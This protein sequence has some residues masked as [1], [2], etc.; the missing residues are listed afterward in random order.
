[1]TA[2]RTLSA[3]MLSTF[4]AGCALLA[5]LPRDTKLDQRLAMIP[6]G[7]L[8][9]KQPVAI[10][11][12]RHQIPFIEAKNDED[13]A[14]A[15][16]LVHAHLRLGQ[17]ELMRRVSQGRISEMAGPIAVDIDH[18]LRI[19]N[20]GRAAAETEKA[21]PP[22][23][24]V[25]AEAFVRGI[26]HYQQNVKKLPAEFA[27]LGMKREPWEVRDILTIG[28]LAS[29]DV[30]WLVWFRL[31]KLRGR[32]EWKQLWARL[33]KSG[34]DSVASFRPAGKQAA[35][36]DIL[37]GLSRSGSNSLA[38]AGSRTGTGAAL[39]ANDPHLGLLLPNLWLLAGV[40]SPSYHAVGLMVPGLPFFALGRNNRIAWGGTNM[41]AASSDLYDASKLEPG[42]ITTRKET[43]KVRWWLDQTVDVR[44]T[45]LGPIISDAP[46]IETGTDKPLALA[47]V[48]HQP[49]DEITAM[50]KANKAKNFSEFRK[51]FDSFAVSAQNMLYADVDGNI[52]QVMA[53][54]LPVRSARR[55]L[56][57]VL[58]P[59]RKSDLWQ[60]Y[61]KT[62]KLP[63][64]Y[65]PKTGFLASANNRPAP[66]KVPLGYFFSTDDRVARMARLMGGQKKITLSDLKAVQIDTYLIS[67]VKL[68]NVMVEGLTALGVG[69]DDDAQKA[70]IAAL[71]EWDGHYRIASK[72][73]VAFELFYHALSGPV[74]KRLYKPEIANAVLGHAQHKALFAEDLK[75][76]KPADLKVD[77]K[78]ALAGAAGKFG[79]Y[80]N[81][82][83]MHRLALR[84][85]L[86]Q[87]PVVG[88]RFRFVDAPAAGSNDTLWKTAHSSTD[89]RHDAR[90]GSNARHISD[91]S[92][93]DANYFV[94]LGGQD[95]WFNSANFTDQVNLW[96]TGKYVQVPLRLS[97][98]RKNTVHKMTLKPTLP[99]PK[100]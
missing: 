18:S 84:H 100:R 40:K 10:Y 80:K 73:P 65:N 57:L 66:F 20:F 74:R 60:G 35:L 97:T 63:A 5:P 2:L 7:N 23:T 53:M 19:L 1:M 79:A 99:A 31:L 92:D 27:M 14:F 70:L 56:D 21:L 69:G 42:A 93:A 95:G 77:L 22:E 55:P 89:A 94:L 58:D 24:R 59:T 88:G 86:G 64:S 46:L 26:N 41:R 17:M 34:G 47:W 29:S 15:L 82:G 83:E 3:V 51:A 87:L 11:W 68:R 85:P 13:L 43:I 98:V 39:M 61:L 49:S 37:R 45:N 48:G 50:L 25:W 78:I 28:R 71:R 44:E 9:L 30:N 33:L 16:G 12:D 38:V 90:Y 91:L 76:L 72:G 6:T 52:G 32:P 54:R 75:R 8:P 96:L 62:T 67:A 36:D 81:W 4:V